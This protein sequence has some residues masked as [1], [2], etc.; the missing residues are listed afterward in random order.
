[1]AVT[2]L[3]REPDAALRPRRVSIL[4]STGSVGH[5]TVDL[6]MRNPHDFTVEAVHVSL[7]EPLAE[8]G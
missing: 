3:T 2:A 7:I 6:L 5:S 8:L 4:G 1:M